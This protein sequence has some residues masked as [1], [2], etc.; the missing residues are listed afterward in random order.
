MS[1]LVVDSGRAVYDKYSL[2]DLIASAGYFC[3]MMM[4]VTSSARAS[5]SRGFPAESFCA[6][7]ALLLK[8]LDLRLPFGSK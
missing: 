4:N 6:S 1:N 3:P 7:G 5:T 8:L 2:L